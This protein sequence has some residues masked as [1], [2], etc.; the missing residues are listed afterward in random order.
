MI[1]AATVE[2]L[3]AFRRERDW[4]QFHSPKNLAI[5]L[6]VEASE[7][8]QEFEWTT[9]DGAPRDL[10]HG[11][12]RL[13]LEIADVAIILTYLTHDLGIDLDAAFTSK[14]A[15]NEEKYPVEKARGSAKKY[16]EL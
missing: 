5:A 6:A 8:L 16:T 3:L 4:E 9:N 15:R 14:M 11:R 7:V 10:A 1:T 2:A 13:L 12:E